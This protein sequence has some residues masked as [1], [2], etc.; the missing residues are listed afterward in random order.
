M[1]VI[2][3]M[4][5]LVSKG[6]NF[7]ST[8]TNKV[9]ENPKTVGALVTLSTG[10]YLSYRNAEAIQ[11]FAGNYISS[12]HPAILPVF[13]ET[14]SNQSSFT[15]AISRFEISDRLQSFFEEYSFESAGTMATLIGILSNSSTLIVGGF[16]AIGISIADRT[17]G[18]I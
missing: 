1:S 17:I 6:S 11:T 4:N 10:A 16:S 8:V 2:N 5:D 18:L 3:S 9:R 13:G 15:S 12:N 7:I 14:V